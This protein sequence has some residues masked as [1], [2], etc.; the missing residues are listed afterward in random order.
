[1]KCLENG[2]RACRGWKLGKQLRFPDFQLRDLLFIWF[3]SSRLIS[4]G[5]K[6]VLVLEPAEIF[7]SLPVKSKVCAQDKELGRGGGLSWEVKDKEGGKTEQKRLD[8]ACQPKAILRY[9]IISFPLLHLDQ[10]PNSPSP[11]ILFGVCWNT[12]CCSW[13]VGDTMFWLEVGMINCFRI[14]LSLHVTQPRTRWRVPLILKQ[15]SRN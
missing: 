1:M 5:F 14:V 9:L 3:C 7:S 15:V 4:Y 10:S 11:L 6:D 13:W 8:V 2:P 12:Y